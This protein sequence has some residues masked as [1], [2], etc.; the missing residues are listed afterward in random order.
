M[1]STV[2]CFN[3][4]YFYIISYLFS[5]TTLPKKY[6]SIGKL[7]EQQEEKEKKLKGETKFR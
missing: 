2:I 7:K 3:K 5:P 6:L 4:T 1:G